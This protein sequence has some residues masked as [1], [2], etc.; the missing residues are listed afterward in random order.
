M[1]QLG[2]TQAVAAWDWGPFA[3]LGVLAA[4]VRV[5]NASSTVSFGALAAHS[6]GYR[7]LDRGARRRRT[8]KLLLQTARVALALDTAVGH[9]G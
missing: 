8:G 7:S 6:A 5:G 9:L 3:A 2:G 1:L 4:R